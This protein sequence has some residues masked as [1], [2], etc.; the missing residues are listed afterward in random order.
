MRCGLVVAWFSVV[1]F[2]SSRT[3]G[4][5]VKAPEGCANLQI[6]KQLVHI[7]LQ[8]AKHTEVKL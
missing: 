7:M 6:A 5:T 8:P 3:S 1:R 2:S 4:K